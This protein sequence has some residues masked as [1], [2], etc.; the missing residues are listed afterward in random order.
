MLNLSWHTWQLETLSSGT[1]WSLVG[2]TAGSCT[3]PSVLEGAG[4]GVGGFSCTSGR[5]EDLELAPGGD[6]T[7][8][9]PS[10]TSLLA[11]REDGW[12]ETGLIRP[13]LWPTVCAKIRGFIHRYILQF[14][15]VL[16]SSK[17]NNLNSLFRISLSSYT[18]SGYYLKLQYMYI[19]QKFNVLIPILLHFIILNH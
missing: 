9:P 11:R 1:H 6:M 17:Q 4:E 10:W 15:L 16:N 2:G 3:C 13:G 14:I 19:N 8:S 12:V 7:W 18:R 5:R